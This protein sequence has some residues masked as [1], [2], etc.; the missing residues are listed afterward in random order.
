MSYLSKYQSK[1]KTD[2]TS[3]GLSDSIFYF[4]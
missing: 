4:P 1:K 2:P 3:A